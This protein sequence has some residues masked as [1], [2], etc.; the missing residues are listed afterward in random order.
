MNK[1]SFKS[2][3]IK[4]KIPSDKENSTDQSGEIFDVLRNVRSHLDKV[5]EMN[6]IDSI[7]DKN[8]EYK[9]TYD[10]IECNLIGCLSVICYAINQNQDTKLKN[11]IIIIVNV[12]K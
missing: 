8:D 9:T 3:F 11:V 6:Q 4:K 12:L 10:T 1:L 5:L 2:Q 7:N